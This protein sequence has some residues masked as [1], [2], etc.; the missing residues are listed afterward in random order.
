MKR[1]IVSI[2]LAI[3]ILQSTVV[4]TVNASSLTT[5]LEGQKNEVEEQV[6]QKKDEQNGIKTQ[7]Q[8]EQTEIE[9][10]DNSISISEEEINSLEIQIDE[11]EKSIAKNQQDLEKKQKEYEE[12]QTFF[13]ERL[14]AMYKTGDVTFLEI[15]FNSANMFDFISKY[16]ALSKITECDLNLLQSL[17]EQQRQIEET[18]KQLEAEKSQLDNA[19]AEK[20]A[21]A[22]MLKATKLQREEKLNSL[23]ETEKALQKDIDAANAKLAQIEKDIA[24]EL[25]RIEEEIKR[26]Q[27]A[28]NK[29]NSTTNGN[30]LHFD[31]SF[32]WPCNNRY[33]TSTV[34]NRWGRKH[35]G[36]DIGASYENVYATASGFAYTLENPSGYGHYIIIIHGNNYISLYG[37]LNA[38]KVSYG[39]YVTQGQVI[40]QSGNSGASQ[41]AHLHFELRRASSIANFFNV[42]PLNPLEYLPGGYTLAPGATTES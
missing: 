21:K 16:Y 26:Q 11:L 6:Q 41:G 1:K 23:S 34:K 19:K 28:N 42:A 4:Y 39:Q 2:I 24:A 32:I 33:I 10:L 29:G 9:K 31:G 18:K 7:I 37:H 40:A 22:K 36:I 20:E 25:K 3:I 5:Q 38:F 12:N 30:G 15:L 8:S 17:E 27:A 13:E 35:K 14:V